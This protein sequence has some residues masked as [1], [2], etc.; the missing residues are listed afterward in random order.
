MYNNDHFMSFVLLRTQREVLIPRCEG[1]Y[2][3]K[4]RSLSSKF[5]DWLHGWCS[6]RL[7]AA[8]A[9]CD[10]K[11]MVCGLK[12]RRSSHKRVILFLFNMESW[13]PGHKIFKDSYNSM[14]AFHHADLVA[15]EALSE[16][17]PQTAQTYNESKLRMAS[18]DP[19]MPM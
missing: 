1:Q 14:I 17:L 6:G 10:R 3:S 18:W 5:P 16:W 15:M 13:H 2:F 8:I 19:T 7:N 12:R 11:Q 9:Q 4:A